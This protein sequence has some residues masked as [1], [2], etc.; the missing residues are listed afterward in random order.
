MNSTQ[1]KYKR[2]EYNARINRVINFINQ[3]LGEELTLKQLAGVANF[4]EYHFHRIFGAMTGEPLNRFIQRL[5]VE[6]AA[7]MLIF[8]PKMSITDIALDCGFSGSSTFA[9]SFRDMFGM[10]ASEWRQGGHKHHSKIRKTESNIPQTESNRRKDIID[11]SM[12]FD[13]DTYNQTWRYQMIDQ[14]EIQVDVREIENMH[15]AYVRHIGPYQGDMQVFETLFSTLMKWAGPR[16]LLARKKAEFLSAYYDSPEITENEKLR[17][18]VCLTVPEDVQ[19][20][21]EVD[22]MDLPGGK[23]AV[24]HFEL[25]ADEYEG[26]WNF[27]FG[28]WLPESGY[29]P[30]DRPSYEFY[31]N[32]PSQ[33]PEG[34][35]I[36]D[37]AIP[38]RPL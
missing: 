1:E 10:T 33:H 28:T 6:K 19:G 8:N 16:D 21:G 17:L 32:D 13:A 22:T 4:S 23:Y 25:K 12:Y 5:R 2:D 3:H 36:V 38:V 18:D 20:E 34:K 30:D 9:R 35:H 27:V 14:T 29:Q 37:I 7:N 31:R 26:A 15:V 24:A 11:S